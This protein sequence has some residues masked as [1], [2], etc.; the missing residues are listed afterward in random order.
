MSICLS[1]CEKVWNIGTQLLK[2]IYQIYSIIE[3][4]KFDM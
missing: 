2:N 4:L 3:R 1:K